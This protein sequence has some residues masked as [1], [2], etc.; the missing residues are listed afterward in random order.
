MLKEKTA[1]SLIRRLQTFCVNDYM[2]VYKPVIGD[3]AVRRFKEM[4]KTPVQFGMSFEARPTEREKMDL[5]GVVQ[6]SMANRRSGQHGIDLSVGAWAIEQI[7]H[8]GNLKE[9]RMVIAYQEEKEKQRLQMEQERAIQLQG[10]Q[11][12]QLKQIEQQTKQMELQAD[13]AKIQTE[14]QMKL[15]NTQ[16]Q[17][18]GDILKDY[19]KERP[20][21]AQSYI[22][23]QQTKANVSAMAGEDLG[24]EIEE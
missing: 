10:Q 19:L 16:A 9:I 1:M 24:W 12:E 13:M 20:E 22:K 5:I 18:M 6:A 23:G 7:N 14:G 8:G 21:E 2:D 15:Q 4:S 17:I 11:N 3:T